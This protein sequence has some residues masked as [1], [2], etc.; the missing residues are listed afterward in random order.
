M[1]NK[2][3]SDVYRTFHMKAFYVVLGLMLLSFVLLLD[4][5]GMQSNTEFAHFTRGVDT[6][7]DFLYYI[8]KSMMY[9]L[10]VLIFVGIFF[11]DEYNS[12]YVKNLYPLHTHKSIL[13]IG[14]YLYCVIIC[15]VFYMAVLAGSFIV[16]LVDPTTF[17]SIQL[18]DYLPFVIMQLLTMAAA[19]SF[20][21][22]LSNLTKSKVLVV[23]YAI[24][25]GTIIYMFVGMIL[26]F[27]F[28][29]VSALQW[30]MYVLSSKLPYTF[31]M[32]AYRNAILVLIGN[33]LLYNGINYLLLK[34]QDI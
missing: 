34:K 10:F 14:K 5:L 25:Y 20:T 16:Q 9:S 28:H 24:G 2:L 1:W 33:T 31:G 18:G 11:T 12:G 3:K 32:D 8:P 13:V 22:L 21:M 26:N 4:D 15:F 23:L 29:D 19:A 30:M 17:G 27:L 7:V 6:F